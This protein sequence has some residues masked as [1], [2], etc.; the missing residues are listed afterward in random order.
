MQGQKKL[1]FDIIRKKFIPLTPEEWVRQHVIHTCVY[2][3]GLAPG[4]LAVEKEVRFGNLKKRFD[5]AALH[6]TG[7]A[8]LLV[9]CK[10]PEVKINTDTWFQSSVYQHS[11]NARFIWL[12]NGLEH[13]WAEW[14]DGVYLAIDMPLR[15]LPETK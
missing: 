15:L 1:I 12:T 5:V 13:Y 10:A 14:N 4:L 8:L 11:L 6:N 2:N 7:D 9:E 3:Y